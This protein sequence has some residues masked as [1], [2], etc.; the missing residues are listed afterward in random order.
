MHDLEKMIVRDAFARTFELDA[1]GEFSKI[2]NLMDK[3]EKEL[4]GRV[5]RLECSV[6]LSVSWVGAFYFNVNL[7][8]YIYINRL[9]KGLADNM[10]SLNVEQAM[11]IVDF[12]AKCS[13]LQ[14]C[15]SITASRNLNHIKRQKNYIEKSSKNNE[16]YIKDLLKGV[17][18][19]LDIEGFSEF[20]K[21]FDD[22]YYNKFSKE[23]RKEIL[24]ARADCD[25]CT[26][27]A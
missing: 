5:E 2:Q 25:Y 14:K 4:D 8:M 16:E 18:H 10:A 7:G 6:V 27:E 11:K 17:V 22:E 15:S 26:L 23:F 20:A 3:Y 19:L 1:E 12:C 13:H 21:R 9:H 24:D